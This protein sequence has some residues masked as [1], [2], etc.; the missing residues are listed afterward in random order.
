VGKIDIDEARDHEQ[1]TINPLGRIHLTHEKICPNK[2]SH[3]LLLTR[4]SDAITEREPPPRACRS[5]APYG[6]AGSRWTG[7]RASSGA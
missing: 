7:W 5:T 6:S 2:R 3:R 1:S 4:F